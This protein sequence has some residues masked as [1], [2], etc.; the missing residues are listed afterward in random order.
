MNSDRMFALAQELAEA[1]GRQDVDAAM[2][3]LH[4][5]MLLETPAFGT[6]VRGHAQVK[7]VLERFFMTFPDYRVSLEG[8]ASSSDVL[9]CWGTVQMT[10][11]GNRF[12][13]TPNGRQ[14]E[15]PVFMKF[16]FKNGLI[17]SE[18]FFFDLSSLCAQS[19]ISTDAVRQKLFCRAP[20]VAVTA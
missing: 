12:G 17:A 13:V 20:S 18:Q 15:L 10:M 11:N 2:K 14:A 19:G 9:V 1:K 7:E 16:G 5:T 8:H 6:R 4:P 3:L